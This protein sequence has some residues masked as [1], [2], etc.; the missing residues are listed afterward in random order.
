MVVAAVQQILK[1]HSDNGC[2]APRR[3]GR[4]L[5]HAKKFVIHKLLN[6]CFYVLSFG[7]DCACRVF[8]PLQHRQSIS[9][10]MFAIRKYKRQL[11][12]EQ[13]DTTSSD[14]NPPF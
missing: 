4:T 5:S 13:F 10:S 9:E 7:I 12:P 1:G 14:Q 3:D 8:F 2:P 11:S 6:L